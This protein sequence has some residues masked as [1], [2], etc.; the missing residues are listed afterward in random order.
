MNL[1]GGMS[2]AQCRVTA[3]AL[4][5][6][7]EVCEESGRSLFDLLLENAWLQKDEYTFLLLSGGELMDAAD[8]NG[9]QKAFYTQERMLAKIDSLLW[10]EE[11]QKEYAEL[12]TLNGGAAIRCKEEAAVIGKSE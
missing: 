9:L 2:D 4:R 6:L 5:L 11:A 12:C 10:S 1:L 3:I 8:V 7:G